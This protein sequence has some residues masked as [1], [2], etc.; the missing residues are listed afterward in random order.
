[1][2]REA[3]VLRHSG[4]PWC[5]PVTPEQ[6]QSVLCLT[7]EYFSN[8]SEKLCTN[9]NLDAENSK[10]WH[11]FGTDIRYMLGANWLML[12]ETSL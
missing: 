1:M 4:E 10:L 2:I 12:H 11:L 8:V 3:T 9:S 5:A 6:A 7:T